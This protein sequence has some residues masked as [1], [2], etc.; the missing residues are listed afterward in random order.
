MTHEQGFAGP[1]RRELKTRL[2]AKAADLRRLASSL[3]EVGKRSHAT[4]PHAE[5]IR[6]QGC[7]ELLARVT[8]ET[9]QLASWLC[10]PLSVMTEEQRDQTLEAAQTLQLGEGFSPLE[11]VKNLEIA[12]RKPHGRP[13][14]K[15]HL[16]V[17]ALDMWLT[18][19]KAAWPRVTREVCNCGQQIHGQVCEEQLRQQVN[20]LKAVLQKMGI[21]LPK[22]GRQRYPL[23]RPAITHPGEK[24]PP[25]SPG[26]K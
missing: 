2:I 12:Q 15:R 25:F 16:A 3:Q 17:L 20:D 26:R 13:A 18:N 22:R 23:K 1:I 6:L 10:P 5:L 4:Q 8:K 24:P 9:E 11:I 21:P 14:T 7:M 19:P